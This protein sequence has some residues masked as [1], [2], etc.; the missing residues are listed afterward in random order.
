MSSIYEF[1]TPL[2][3]MCAEQIFDGDSRLRLSRQSTPDQYGLEIRRLSEREWHYCKYCYQ[4]VPTFKLLEA[5]YEYPK[6]QTIDG[7]DEILVI[8]CCWQCG[9][10][11]DQLHDFRKRKRRLLG[12]REKK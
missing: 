10:G 3:R 4:D 6:K 2:M 1:D 12:R 9:Y 11:L 8:R 5:T 7:Y